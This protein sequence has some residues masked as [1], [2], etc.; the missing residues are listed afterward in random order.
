MSNSQDVDGGRR[1]RTQNNTTTL[2][3]CIDSNPQQCGCASNYQM[4]YRGTKNITKNGHKCDPWK[5]G[6]L[7]SYPNAG[8]EDGPYCRNPD[9]I[10]DT[11]RAWCFVTLDDGQQVYEL[12]DVP[13]CFP[14]IETC[15]SQFNGSD[16]D[17]LVGSDGIDSSTN[18]GDDCASCA[19]DYTTCIHN[20][21]DNISIYDQVIDESKAGVCVLMRYGIVHLVVMIAYLIRLD[22]MQ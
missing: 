16:N 8:L 4:D 5:S 14:S 6:M 10:A 2:S 3:T 18:S 12:C 15:N 19:C 17:E 22:E 9:S 11:D 13:Y 21:G 20:S 1:R 7:T